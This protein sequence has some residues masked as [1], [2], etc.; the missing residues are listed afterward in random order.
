MRNAGLNMIVT[1]LSVQRQY[2]TLKQ[3]EDCYI[4]HI[5]SLNK[6]N[7][8]RTAEALGVTRRTLQR[9]LSRG[10]NVDERLGVNTLEFNLGAQAQSPAA[11]RSEPLIVTALNLLLN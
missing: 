6:G 8:T 3:L 11:Q 10:L 5:L 1:P 4:Q 2:P 9:K 7:V